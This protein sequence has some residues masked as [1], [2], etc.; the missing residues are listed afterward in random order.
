MSFIFLIILLVGMYALIFV[1][2]NRQKK[3]HKETINNLKNGD[4]IQTIGGIVG[5][6]LNVNLTDG[7]VIINSEGSRIKFNIQ[8]VSH[9]LEV[10]EEKENQSFEE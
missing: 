8:S 4:R 6:V 5:E 10:K 9:V 1:P 7:Y 3:K 2:Q